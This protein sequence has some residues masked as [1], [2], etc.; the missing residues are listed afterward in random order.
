MHKNESGTTGVPNSRSKGLN[1]LTPIAILTCL[2]INVNTF[3]VFLAV[4]LFSVKSALL[5][6]KLDSSY[7]SMGDCNDRLGYGRT[8]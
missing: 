6:G 5:L 3:L 8:S 1:R 2:E 4:K 7:F